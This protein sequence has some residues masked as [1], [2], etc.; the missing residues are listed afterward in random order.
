MTKRKE[1]YL[2][3]LIL[4]GFYDATQN[5]NR[6]TKS[7]DFVQ[8]ILKPLMPYYSLEIDATTKKRIFDGKRTV[9]NGYYEI[10]DCIKEVGRGQLIISYAEQLKNTNIK[11]NSCFDLKASM[12]V[13]RKIIE[14]S[15][16][17]DYQL[18]KELLKSYRRNY[19]KYPYIFLAES[20]FYAIVTDLNKPCTYIELVRPFAKH[21]NY[22]N[23]LTDSP[24][25]PVDKFMGRNDH[26]DYLKEKVIYD[27]QNVILYGLSGIGKT[28]LMKD[29]WI[30]AKKEFGHVAWI[31]YKNDLKASLC[32]QFLDIDW[33]ISEEERSKLVSKCINDLGDS[34]LIIIDN[35]S[36]FDKKDYFL[37]QLTGASCSVLV[38]SKEPVEYDNFITR[39]IPA[40]SEEDCIRLYL[41]HRYSEQYILEN[42]LEK[43][44]LEKILSSIGWHTLT[45]ELLAKTA[46]FES[47]DLY[48]LRDTL[49]ENG[50]NFSEMRIGTSHENL[51]EYAT[52]NRHIKILFSIAEDGFSE[53]EINILKKLSVFSGLRFSHIQLR[54]ILN[55]DICTELQQL[56]D[57]GWVTKEQS[58]MTTEN[59]ETYSVH[60]IPAYA[61]QEQFNMN[62]MYADLLNS[63]TTILNYEKTETLVSM[64]PYLEKI[65]DCFS[66]MFYSTEDVQLLTAIGTMIRDYGGNYSKA[67]KIFSD[68]LNNLSDDNSTITAQKAELLYELGVTYFNQGNYEDAE[69]EIVR[70]LECKDLSS[71]EKNIIW[72]ALACVYRAQGRLE[73]AKKLFEQ[74]LNNLDTTLSENKELADSL[75]SNL[76]IVH[77]KLGDFKEA[78]KK[79]LDSLQFIEEGTIALATTYDNL[80]ALFSQINKPDKYKEYVEKSLEIKKRILGDTHID[81]LFTLRNS[82]H[83]DFEN[84]NIS[85]AKEKLEFIQNELEFM[86]EYQ[87]DIYETYLALATIHAKLLDFNKSLTFYEKALSLAVLIFGKTHTETAYVYNEIGELHLNH[88]DYYLAEANLK[89]AQS[90]LRELSNQNKIEAA[91]VYRNLGRLYLKINKKDEAIEKIS[92]ALKIYDSVL[93]QS[94]PETTKT[95]DLLIISNK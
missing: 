21:T 22:R 19:K 8:G 16:F 81:T 32:N 64:I 45:I 7:G 67:E 23:I 82:A 49:K 62:S 92:S 88:N 58:E 5:K 63:V 73:E 54:E 44:I 40:L 91:D 6:W 53:K 80:S 95:R 68:A 90:I 69:K 85:K 55:I 46:K 89:T 11:D 30:K 17:I 35:F 83:I 47:M 38:T 2:L 14:D 1:K 31:T 18:Q 94:H 24:A 27:S 10:E 72:N 39:K 15:I 65:T 34:L 3:S 93:G 78:E 79:Y 50:L 60:E 28:E 61:I 77:F 51:L 76:G 29:F 25:L 43:R 57:K 74:I 33:G 48:E 59:Y 4:N 66:H 84:G 36:S 86:T 37:Q 52:V 9:S 42:Q 87:N 56:V 26:L 13:T 12:R 75:N 71:E 20:I 70:S 41:N